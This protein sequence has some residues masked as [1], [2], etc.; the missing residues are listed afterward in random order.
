MGPEH[1]AVRAIPN[2]GSGGVMVQALWRRWVRVLAWALLGGLHIYYVVRLVH[3]PDR[4][5]A[6]TTISDARASMAAQQELLFIWALGA[7]LW[8]MAPVFP[9]ERP[10]TW[11]ALAWSLAGVASLTRP[12]GVYSLVVPLVLLGLS[13]AI[14]T[15]LT[16]GRPRPRA[17]RRYP[18]V[19]RPLRKKQ[20][21][22]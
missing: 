8:F 13:F 20:S 14:A 9:R 16:I 12:L 5:V 21:A 17:R 15:L 2:S 19:E 7:G 6:F 1:G 3:L 4:N 22:R 18:S 10:W 11:G